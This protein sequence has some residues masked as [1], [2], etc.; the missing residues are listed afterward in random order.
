M[1]DMKIPVAHASIYATNAKRVAEIAKITTSV[2]PVANMRYG[3][4]GNL[5]MTQPVAMRPM[6]IDIQNKLTESDAVLAERCKWFAK[7]AGKKLLTHDSTPTYTRMANIKRAKSSHF[8]DRRAI[9]TAAVGASI[10]PLWCSGCTI[11]VMNVIVASRTASAPTTKKSSRHMP[12]R[13]NQLAKSGVITQPSPK[14]ASVRL[15]TTARLVGNH[16][17][18]DV[19]MVACKRAMPTPL[20]SDIAIH[21]Q[22]VGRAPKT[23]S[24]MPVAVA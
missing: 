3:R 5:R 22:T 8:S 6:T 15:I 11:G 20:M 4:Y 19:E 16:S 1:P 23:I 18:S 12:T 14:A 21:H 9:F 2:P 10:G 13:I 7:M 17:T 24:A